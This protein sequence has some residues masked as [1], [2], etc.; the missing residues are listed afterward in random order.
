M[1][2]QT[3]EFSRI[4]SV[5]RIPPKGIE[6]HLE[7]KPSEREALAKRFDLIDLP[8]LKAHLTLTPGSQQTIEATGTIEAEV[9][10]RCVVSLETVANRLRID[11]DT[12]FIPSDEGQ[13]AKPP[14]DELEEEF[15]FFAGGK[16]DLGEMVAQTL[17]VNLDPY[18]RKADAELKKNEFGPKAENVRPFESLQAT[19][20]TNKNKGK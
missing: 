8:M 9:H 5:A 15:E 10:Q 17:G 2:E 12:V 13:P 19:I 1:T 6:E 11:V 20:K 7:A 16:I 3:P 4:V 18:P 14:S